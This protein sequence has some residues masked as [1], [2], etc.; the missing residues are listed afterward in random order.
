VAMTANA[1]QEDREAC[2]AAGMDDY[3]AKPIRIDQLREAL[4]RG[5]PPAPAA[6]GASRN[7]PVA[8]DQ[9]RAQFDDETVVSELIETFLREAP[10]LVAA[11]GGDEPED[12][13][14]AAHT[15]KSNAQMLGAEELGRLCEELEGL[16]RGG[17]L[18]GAAERIA[19]IEEE[20][21]GVERALRT[22]E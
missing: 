1:L 7:Q 11:M 8:L 22:A 16:A 15:L 12:V 13:R 5:Q 21:A 3:L 18:N 14:R 6:E 17:A 9:L 10:K 20:Y 2:L 4:D 19:A